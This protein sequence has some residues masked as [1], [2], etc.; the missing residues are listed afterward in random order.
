MAKTIGER[1]RESIPAGK[2]QQEIAN[3]VPT[4]LSSF[5]N[6]LNNKVTIPVCALEPLAKSLNKSISWLVTGAESSGA[7]LKIYDV[8]FSA[9]C[10]SFIAQ[11]NIKSNI[12]LPNEFFETYNITPETS[13]GVLV[14]GDSMQPKFFDG[15]IAILDMTIKQFTN[16]GVYAFVYDG[17]CFIKKLQMIGNEMKVVSINAE[18]EPW[19]IT[20]E[21]SFMIVGKVKAGICKF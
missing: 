17:C 5:K 14:R 2:T 18:Y 10:G 21:I 11:E 19:S 9:G 8:E 6:W 1:I 7:S 15:D 20:K 12:V 3:S 13:A 4:S 16:D